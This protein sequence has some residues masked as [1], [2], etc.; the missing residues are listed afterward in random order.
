MTTGTV[1]QASGYSN[2]YYSTS[3]IDLIKVHE[4]HSKCLLES[5]ACLIA[6]TIL[7]DYGAFEC[8]ATEFLQ[9]RA[10]KVPMSQELLSILR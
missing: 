2:L 4:V 3:R 5:L 6:A 9:W 7:D 1:F 10:N 8:Y